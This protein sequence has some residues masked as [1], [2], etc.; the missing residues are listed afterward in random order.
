VF[1]GWHR[2]PLPRRRRRGTANP[3]HV[4]LDVTTKDLQRRFHQAHHAVGVATRAAT[5]DDAATFL[6]SVEEGEWI[7]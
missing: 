3:I 4:T 5:F 6:Q 2:N 7:A 1:D